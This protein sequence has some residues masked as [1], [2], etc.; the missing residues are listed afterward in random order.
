M[1]SPTRSTIVL[2]DD[3]RDI[4]YYFTH[5]IQR[6]FPA[7]TTYACQTSADA[8]AY[9]CRETTCCILTDYSLAYEDS[10]FLINVVHQ[11]WPTIPIVLV[12]GFEPSRMKH[13][14][15]RCA[16][17]LRKPIPLAT[18]RTTL[19]PLLVSAAQS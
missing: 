15:A 11:R 12:T 14:A 13:E 17:V 10:S 19:Q 1:T 9:L 3:D 5:F 2:L 4:L 7:Y 18:F 6:L 8:F 16:A